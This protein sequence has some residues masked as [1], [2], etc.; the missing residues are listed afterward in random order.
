M[1]D[2]LAARHQ[3]RGEF[4]ATFE[5][6][7]SRKVGLGYC[8]RTV[9]LLEVRD[10]KGSRVADHLWMD[11]GRQLAGL[12]LARGDRVRFTARVTSYWKGCRAHSAYLEEY[13]APPEKDFRLSHPSN[14][15]KVLSDDYI[16][17]LPLFK[18]GD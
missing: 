4:S 3:L 7:G 6:F 18:A 10:N 2:E 16:G 11:L 12:Q 13:A 8:K 5:R 9:L 15:R 17:S 1:R 14:M